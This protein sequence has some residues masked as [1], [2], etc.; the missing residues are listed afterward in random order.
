MCLNSTERLI[1]R[2]VRVTRLASIRIIAKGQLYLKHTEANGPKAG[3]SIP[4]IF[5]T[6]NGQGG[7]VKNPLGQGEQR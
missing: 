5:V 1:V 2:N 4:I 6:H 3:F 7:F